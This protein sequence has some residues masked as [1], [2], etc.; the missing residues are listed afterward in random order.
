[1]TTTKGRC[2]C[3]AIAH[4]FDGAPRWVMHC[5]CQSCRRA[6]SSVLATYLGVRLEQFRYLKGEPAQYASSPGVK[7]YFCGTCGSPMAYTGERWPG[8]VHLL[9]GTLVD[10]GQWP[11]TAHAYISEQ[12]PWFEVHDHLPRYSATA[13][14][15]AVPLRKGP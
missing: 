14:G 8:E 7:R 3:G 15:G 6:V 1:M 2:Q 5:H 12:L 10:P 4:E 9:H 13:G 11:P